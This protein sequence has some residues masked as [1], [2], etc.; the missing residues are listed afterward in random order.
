MEEPACLWTARCALWEKMT[1]LRNNDRKTKEERLFALAK[2]PPLGPTKT[3]GCFSHL[4]SDFSTPQA[5]KSSSF[6]LTLECWNT[7]INP[8][9]DRKIWRQAIHMF[10]NM[11]KTF[12]IQL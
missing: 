4:S 8:G 2:I 12:C 6:F 9:K 7:W 3:S 11:E 1:S 5:K 10:H